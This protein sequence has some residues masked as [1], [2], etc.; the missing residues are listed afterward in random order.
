MLSRR[1]F[2]SLSL[3]LLASPVAAAPTPAPKLLKP[4]QVPSY[5][6]TFVAY[7]DTRSNPAIHARIIQEITHLQPHPEFV[8]QSGDLVSD[9]NNSAQWAEFAKIIRPLED[10]YIDYYPARGNR[11]VGPYFTEYVR[12]TVASGDKIHKYYYAFARNNN[13]F[14]I[15]DSMQSC[16]P[17]SVQYQWLVSELAKTA[18]YDNLFVTFHESP[19]SIGPHGP[20]G[21]ARKYLHPLFVQYHPRAVFCGHDHLYYRTTRDGVTY[22]LTGGGG[23]PQY[24]PEN[25]SLAIPGDV[26]IHDTD[27]Q[28]K[29]LSDEVYNAL[30]PHVVQC[31]VNGSRVTLTA[32][33]PDGSVIDKFALGPK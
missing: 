5:P 2:L 24:R 19:F 9:G 3:G 25:K 6:F 1:S 14:V 30:I 23:A 16:A 18:Q 33:R 32:V 10:T 11:D 15:V 12:Q 28:G 20:V 13:R 4:G 29:P 17:G 21:D 27:A 22:V 26:Y 7:G 8:L 31:D